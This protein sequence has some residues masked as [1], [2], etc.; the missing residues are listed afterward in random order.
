MYLFTFMAGA[1]HYSLNVVGRKLSPGY[2]K[3]KYRNIYVI[4]TMKTWQYF[5]L[6]KPAHITGKSKQTCL[7][8]LIMFVVAPDLRCI[9]AFNH[10][11]QWPGYSYPH[12]L[13]FVKHSNAPRNF[14]YA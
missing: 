11:W 8:C 4:R 14:F 6:P 3:Q 1:A 12:R 9:P 10:D 2:R 5:A 13:E 7:I